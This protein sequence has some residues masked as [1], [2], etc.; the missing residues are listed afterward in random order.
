MR[1]SLLEILGVLAV[2]LAAGVGFMHY[3]TTMPGS[4]RPGPLPPITPELTA[5][6]DRLAA[7]V[8]YLYRDIG[9]RHQ[10]IPANLDATAAYIGAELAAAGY[11]VRIEEYRSGRA[12]VRNVEAELAGQGKELIVVGA[13]YDTLASSKGA[14][15]NASGVAALLEIARQLAG[16][17]FSHTLRFVAFANGE[18]PYFGTERMGSWVYARRASRRGERIRAM[19]SLEMLGYYNDSPGSQ[20]YPRVI[21][22][23]FPDTANFVAF[24][25][26][27][28]SRPLLV[29]SIGAYRALATVRAEGITAPLLLGAS[30]PA[31]R[32]LVLLGLRLPGRDDH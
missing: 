23:F 18:R 12:Q 30:Y 27:F 14:N 10:S 32:S 24:V 16:R 26:D 11:R 5:Q 7:D 2:C 28:E 15:D 22:P 6:A 21:A 25:S 9:V 29:D 1:R 13:H 20:R 8:V 4:E 31:L 3:C 17:R 19:Y